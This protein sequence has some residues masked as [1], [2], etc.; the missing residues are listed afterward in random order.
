VVYDNTNAACLFAVDTSL[1][2]LCQGESTAFTEFSVVSNSLA[3]DSGAEECEGADTKLG[4]LGFA[5]CTSANLAAGLIE[6]GAHAALPVLAEVVTVKNVVVCV[7]H[8]LS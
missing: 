3:T 7:T 6:P 4:G 1:F 8:L 2:E 5:S